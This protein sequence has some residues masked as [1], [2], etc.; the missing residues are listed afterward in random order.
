MK[1]TLVELLRQKEIM[2]HDF[3]CTS[4]DDMYYRELADKVRYFKEDE[5]E[6]NAM[7]KVIEDMRNE[8]ARKAEEQT[9]VFHIKNMMNNLKFTLDQAMNAL[10]IPQAE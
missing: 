4:A 3:S 2:M 1:D 8:T 6:M 5:K 9:T 10:G 7:C